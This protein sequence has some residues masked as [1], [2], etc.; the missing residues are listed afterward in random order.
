VGEWRYS[1]TILGLGTRWRCVASFTLRPVYLR[2]KNSDTLW[3]GSW[4]DPKADLE[5]VEIRK[6]S[7]RE[8]LLVSNEIIELQRLRLPFKKNKFRHK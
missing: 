3:I 7:C 8:L 4:V 2:G 5:A 1:S 6:T